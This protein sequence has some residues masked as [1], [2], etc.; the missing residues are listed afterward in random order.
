MPCVRRLGSLCMYYVLDNLDYVF[1][2]SLEPLRPSRNGD[3]LSCQ[4]PGRPGAGQLGQHLHLPTF[5]AVWCG[6]GPGGVAFETFQVRDEIFTCGSLGRPCAWATGSLN[7][8]PLAR[9]SACR[10]HPHQGMGSSLRSRNHL[11]GTTWHAL[12]AQVQ[13]RVRSTDTGRDRQRQRPECQS[14]QAEA[15][16]R[17]GGPLCLCYLASQFRC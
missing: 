3:V 13:P 10:A 11:A 5:I 12:S 9:L 17:L 2:S 4:V 16:T 14:A 6:P 7:Q 1:G 8:Y 15:A